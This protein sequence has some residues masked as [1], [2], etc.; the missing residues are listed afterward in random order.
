M[1]DD[2]F[3]AQLAALLGTPEITAE[4]RTAVLDLTR[5]VAHGSERR[6]APLTAWALALTLSAEDS[7]DERT[8]RVRA[9]ITALEA[10]MADGADPD[11]GG[12]AAADAAST[13]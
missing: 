1:S 12:T 7:A 5:V 4:E 11:E 13:A 6:Y 9:A 8:A 2:A 3:F 10:T